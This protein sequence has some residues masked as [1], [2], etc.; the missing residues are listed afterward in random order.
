MKRLHVPTELAIIAGSLTLGVP[1]AI[2]LF[3][4]T[5]AVSVEHLESEFHHKR[6]VDGNPISTAYFH[7][8]L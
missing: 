6:D 5:V 7:K 3:S 1:A 8:G 4:P 2:A